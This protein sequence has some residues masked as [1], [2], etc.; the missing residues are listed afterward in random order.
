MASMTQEPPPNLDPRIYYAAQRTHLAWIRTGLALMGFGFVVAR[1]G[2]FL[3]AMAA[4]PVPIPV[5]NGGVSVWFGT[6]LI[7][8]GV[9]V[10]LVATG[11]HVLEVGRLQR[12]EIIVPRRFA[13]GFVLAIVLAVLG[14]A[15]AAYLLTFR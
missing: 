1:F 15:M 3:R 8:L 5:E 11:Q 7:L 10:Q 4:Q 13:T 12:G 14:L 9:V 2:V 6:T